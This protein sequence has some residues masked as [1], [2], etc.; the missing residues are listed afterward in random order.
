MA[1]EL[2]PAFTAPPPLDLAEAFREAVG[3]G[4]P[5][6]WVLSP[7]TD[8]WAALLK[9]AEE[10][11]QDKKMQVGRLGP[12]GHPGGARCRNRRYMKERGVVLMYVGS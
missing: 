9:F 4:V 6:L 5:L 7:G 3:P 10:R 8:P 12:C 11:G 1:A 2:G